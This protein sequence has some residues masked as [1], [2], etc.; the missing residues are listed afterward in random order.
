MFMLPVDIFKARCLLRVARCALSERDPWFNVIQKESLAC[1]RAGLFQ[2]STGLNLKK[3]LPTLACG[4][5]AFGATAGA[6]AGMTFFYYFC[7]RQ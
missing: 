4:T 1:G 2:S 6:R 7:K 5:G 3:M